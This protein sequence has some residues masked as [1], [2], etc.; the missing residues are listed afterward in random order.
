MTA[1]ELLGHV[2][3]WA[4]PQP[5]EPGAVVNPFAEDLDRE[6]RLLERKIAAGASFVQSQMVFD[7]D[8]LAAFVERARDLLAGVR[9]YASVA[10]LRTA[11]MAE[12]AARLPGVVIPD[13]AARE[14]AGGRG[15]ALATRLASELAAVDAVDALHVFPLGAERETREVA[16]AFRAAKGAPATRR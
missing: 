8:A 13:G 7:L 11:A 5:L 2:R 16:G 1:T 9:F 12:R 14:I 4:A 10:L 15:V 6:L 3:E